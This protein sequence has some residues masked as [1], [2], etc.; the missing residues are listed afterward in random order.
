MQESGP[1]RELRWTQ[2]PGAAGLKA[3]RL[4]GERRQGQGPGTDGAL[5][6][7]NASIWEGRR[8]IS[9]TDNM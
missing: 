6:Q 1:G 4:V 3:A 5:V 2:D 8:G 7:C 9:K